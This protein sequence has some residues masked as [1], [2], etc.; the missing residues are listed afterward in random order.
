MLGWQV[1]GDSL[2]LI[3]ANW[4][5]STAY[6]QEHPCPDVANKSYYLHTF[7]HHIPTPFTP[8]GIPGAGPRVD[9]HACRHPRLPRR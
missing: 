5:R 9:T 3:L 6:M 2:L 8:A 4:A 7:S 1:G